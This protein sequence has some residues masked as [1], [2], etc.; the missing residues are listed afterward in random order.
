MIVLTNGKKVFPEEL[1]SLIG[2]IPGVKESVV[3]GEE[4]ARDAV[5]IV[6]SI[7]IDREKIAAAAGSA[8]DSAIITMLQSKIKE[9][10]AMMP[11]YK[12]IKYFVITEKD[13]AKTTTLK[14]KRPVVI[15]AIH[16]KL[17]AA[18]H[19]MKSVHMRN[20]DLL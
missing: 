10:S 8:E 16:D 5:D 4:S 15:Q 17:K 9:V 7:L 13:F 12:V 3:W 14:I 20:Y 11:S 19:T 2:Q 6:A 18:N 1:E